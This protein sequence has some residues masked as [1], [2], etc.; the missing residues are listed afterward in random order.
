MSRETVKLPFD[1]M[2]LVTTIE[3]EG[4][5]GVYVRAHDGKFYFKRKGHEQ[6]EKKPSLS[7]I[8]KMLQEERDRKAAETPVKV[9]SAGRHASQIE[10]HMIVGL[11][12]NRWIDTKGE[13]VYSYYS[14]FLYNAEAIEDLKLLSS[15]RK[16]AEEEFEKR[17]QAIFKKCRRVDSL[18]D[19]IRIQEEIKK[20]VIKP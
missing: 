7:A 10:T 8:K 6:W 1:D 17:E 4:G 13:E 16:K 9:F 20:G 11:R 15:D 2:T 14:L 18:P 12:K 19:L 3:E 5:I